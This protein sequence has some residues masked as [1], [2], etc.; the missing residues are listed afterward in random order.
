MLIGC[1]ILILALLLLVAFYMHN[2]GLRRDMILREAEEHM[3]RSLLQNAPFPVIVTSMAHNTVRFVNDRALQQFAIGSHELVGAST[4]VFWLR[5]EERERFV[6][7]VVLYGTISDWEAELKTWKGQHFWALLS[8]TQATLDDGMA[9][10]VAIHDVTER[11][12]RDQELRQTHE[13][14]EQTNARLQATLAEI[15]TLA[16]TDKLT[17]CWN[18]RHLEEVV[19]VEI[20]RAR[21]YH[22]P[23]SLIVFDIDHF[24]QVNDR[25]GHGVGDMVLKA[26]ADSIRHHLRES[27]TLARWGGE[28][29]VVLAVNTAQNE[30]VALAEKLRLV[31][32]EAVFPEVGAMT[33]S[34]GVSQFKLVDNFETVFK[35]ADHALYKAKAKGRNRVWISGQASMTVE[36]KG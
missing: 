8:A 9:M 4:S 36:A 3:L 35:R 12:R 32:Q 20:G 15:E 17:G 25:F 29:F 1:A 34:L 18:R 10:I 6:K 2:R 30:A 22:L 13:D 21:R 27:D 16:R 31:V 23:L 28:E 5:P 14:L 11:K 33:I 26:L 7:D 19:G 24:K